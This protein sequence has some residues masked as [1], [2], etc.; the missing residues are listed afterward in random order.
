MFG[1]SDDKSGDLNKSLDKDVLCA[2][3]SSISSPQCKTIATAN[4]ITYSYNSFAQR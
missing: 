1:L 4:N 2:R 3:L